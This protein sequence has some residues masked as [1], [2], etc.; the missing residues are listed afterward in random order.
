VGVTAQ[1]AVGVKRSS[2]GCLTVTV[3]E[4]SDQG[5]R[6][7]KTDCGVNA[8]YIFRP[9][10]VFLA[11]ANVA[12]E[13]A[14]FFVRERTTLSSRRSA[15]ALAIVPALLTLIALY[16][17]NYPARPQ[18]FSPLLMLS[19]FAAVLI[20]GGRLVIRRQRLVGAIAL[21]FLF[22][23]VAMQ[24]L[25]SF[26]PGWFGENRSAN[27]PAGAAAKT[28]TEI[29]HT[30][31]GRPLEFI[32]GERVQSAQVAILSSDRPRI[33]I[34]AD[35]KTSP[36]IDEAEFKKKGGIVF[37][38]I[39]GADNAPPA[40]ISARLPAFAEEAPLRLPWARGGG[41]PIRLGW[42]IVPPQP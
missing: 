39:R 8:R 34:G 9:F 16:A 25:F 14:P 26:A 29:Y 36:W 18:F 30:R 31:T 32:V 5:P 4:T 2:D 28:F 40:E 23:P 42:A 17:L 22:A 3:D 37:W 1:R 10:G 20:G 12:K 19:G 13:S 38:E 41:D 11:T 6:S 21:I 35:T 15:I 24:F 7:A 27:W 33:F